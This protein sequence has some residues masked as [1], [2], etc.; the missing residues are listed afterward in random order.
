MM[1]K[2]PFTKG[3]LNTFKNKTIAKGSLEKPNP[4]TKPISRAAEAESNAVAKAERHDGFTMEGELTLHLW[5]EEKP[6]GRKETAREQGRGMD[7]FKQ[8]MV[9]I[10]TT[11]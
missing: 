1:G 7:P 3:D 2:S 4:K 8:Y 5:K 6:N 11:I 10:N 9:I